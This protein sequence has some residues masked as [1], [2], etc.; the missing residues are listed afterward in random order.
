MSELRIQLFGRLKVH[1]DHELL[2]GFE[3]RKVQELL[4]YLVLNH[5]QAHAREV[6][7]TLLWGDY[8]TTQSRK[9]LRH[10]LWQLKS[11]LEKTCPI[12]ASLLHVE[13]CW[14]NLDISS[15]VWVDALEFHA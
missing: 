14:V 9:L 15:N 8:P 10:A 11:I 7:A 2:P 4:V 1:Y 12:G 3:A 6:L 5:R 13:P